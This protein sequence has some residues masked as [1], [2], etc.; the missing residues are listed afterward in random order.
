MKPLQRLLVPFANELQC[1]ARFKTLEIFWLQNPGA[2]HE[3]EDDIVSVHL[4]IYLF[5]FSNI[6]AA[7]CYDVNVCCRL[8]QN[9]DQRVNSVP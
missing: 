1:I 5:I 4:A 8:I 3:H 2:S 9:I 6:S 7:Y